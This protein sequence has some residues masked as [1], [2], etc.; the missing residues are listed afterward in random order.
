MRQVF[1]VRHAEAE[2]AVEAAHAGRP[3]KERQ[4]TDT[5]KRDMRKG[6]AGLAGVVDGIAVILT[7]PLTRA[8]QTAELLQVAFPQAKLKQHAYLAPGVDPAALLKSIAKL[9]TP[10]AL[11]GHEPDLSQWAGYLCTGTSRSVVR[12]KKG[13]VC[14]LDMPEPALVGE[15]CIA[16]LLTLKQLGKLAR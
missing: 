4:L 10:V 3:D 5:G 15:A 1:L 6:A 14:R 7:S 9:P 16:W 2:D 12:M 11:V 8:V 13:S